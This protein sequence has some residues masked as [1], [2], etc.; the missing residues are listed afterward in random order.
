MHLWALGTGIS[1]S[2]QIRLYKYL[3]RG[4]AADSWNLEKMCKG[5]L[6]KTA[7][8]ASRRT[9]ELYRGIRYILNTE[10]FHATCIHLI[11][12]MPIKQ[13]SLVCADFRELTNA[14]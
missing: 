3:F 7:T 8:C 1:G 2:L 9:A 14:E 11:S 10:R 6:N 12:L 5:D 4:W 13:H